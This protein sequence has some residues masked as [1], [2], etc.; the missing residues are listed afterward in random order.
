MR[1]VAVLAVALLWGSL[2][3]CGGDDSQPTGIDTGG[4]DQDGG[5]DEVCVDQDDDGY[6]KHCALGSDCDDNDPGVT[7]ECRR[8]RV[9]ATDCPCTPGTKPTGC[10]PAVQHVAGGIL[11]CKEGNRYCRAGYWSDCESI[12]EYVFMAVP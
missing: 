8:C 1:A 4:S 11:V 3:A 2:V 7:D 10:E 9:A 5:A 6:G 12:G